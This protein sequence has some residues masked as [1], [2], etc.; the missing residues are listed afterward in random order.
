MAYN[1][2]LWQD[3]G[4]SVTHSPGEGFMQSLT[5][6]EACI[7][8][9]AVLSAWTWICITAKF[10]RE[11]TR[12]MYCGGSSSIYCHVCHVCHVCLFVCLFAVQIL[13]SGEDWN[14][15]YRKGL[16]KTSWRGDPSR[17]LGVNFCQWF[18]VA[19][20]SLPNILSSELPDLTLG[21][22]RWVSEWKRTPKSTVWNGDVDPTLAN[23]KDTLNHLGKPTGF[24]VCLPRHHFSFGSLWKNKF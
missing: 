9:L 18:F 17:K 5:T 15:F 19:F 21:A 22:F 2:A 10:K 24:F 4:R 12:T 13:F 11:S 8:M 23:Q 20:F 16:L 3:N 1:K 6:P 7:M 14:F